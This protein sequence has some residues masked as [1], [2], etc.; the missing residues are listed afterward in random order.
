VRHA[1]GAVLL[2]ARRPKEAEEAY[3]EDLRRWPENGWSLYGL[4]QA[5]VRQKGREA[6]AREIA[7]RFQKAWGAAS[8]PIVASCACAAP[9]PPGSAR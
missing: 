6:E 8:F 4:Q 3:R 1:L 9:R 7:G 5:V 2:A